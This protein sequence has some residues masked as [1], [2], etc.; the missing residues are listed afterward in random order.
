VSGAAIRLAVFDCD[1]TLVDSQG[2]IV[3]AMSAAFEAAGLVVPDAHAIRHVVGLPLIEAILRLAPDAGDPE[4]L[5]DFY[6]DAYGARMGLPDFQEPLFPGA[7][8]TLDALE[9]AG[10]LLG[11]ATGKGRG[12]LVRLLDRHD[13]TK[14]FV[15]LQTA[16]DCPGKPNPEML[17]RAMAEA[18][19]DRS[20][21][22]M[23]GDTAF[24]MQ[25]A[26]NARVAS[27]GVAWG[28]HDTA[29]LIVAGAERVAEDFAAV[30]G[31]VDALTRGR[32]CA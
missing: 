1:G 23:I 32:Q 3:A 26:R 30:P 9:Q 28:Y 31:L 7:G 12:G 2:I 10:Y 21:T 24:D 25:M 20:A 27:I 4:R 19:A 11:V 17:L 13:L 6:R 16:D 8:V 18:G 22:V 15:T 14:R 29:D 5:G